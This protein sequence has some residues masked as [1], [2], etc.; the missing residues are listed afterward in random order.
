M[1]LAGNGCRMARVAVE[2]GRGVPLGE[3]VGD[4][5]AKGRSQAAARRAVAARI[6]RILNLT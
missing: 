1:T 5:P 2:W 3:G 6:T 4:V